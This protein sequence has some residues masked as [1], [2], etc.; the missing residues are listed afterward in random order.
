M[1]EL[2]DAA[3]AVL[4]RARS[5]HDPS[6]LDCERSLSRLHDELSFDLELP[7]AA[8]GEAGLGEAGLGET[9]MST[10][11]K[12]ASLISAKGMKLYLVIAALGSAVG[13]ALLLPNRGVE[14]TAL[15]DRSEAVRV[16]PRADSQIA[17]VQPVLTA[18][19]KS[20][21]VGAVVSPVIEAPVARSRSSSART[22]SDTPRV[23][24]ARS[25][26]EPT[27]VSEPQAAVTPEAPSRATEVVVTPK[28]PKTAASELALI[29]R[30]ATSLRDQQPARALAALDEHLA[31][32]PA[33][34]LRT[35]RQ[36]L[37]VLALCA[38]GRVEQGQRE[39]TAFL[40]HASKTPLASRVRSACSK[41]V[42]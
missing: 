26:V 7:D 15:A 33:G 4:Q 22:R 42:P 14:Q 2:P 5:T 25:N 34:L 10:A 6:A 30:A 1:N 27:T 20:A 23:S 31:L 21:P 16:A 24:R 38:A 35:E 9:G 29:D 36:G 37:R 32:Y 39:Q 28:A 19:P 40:S 13:A 3:K 18:E 17:T 41:S 11:V 12:S 8:L